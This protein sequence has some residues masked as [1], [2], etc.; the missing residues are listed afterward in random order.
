MR[1]PDG[2]SLSRDALLGGSPEPSSSERS[3]CAVCEK[4]SMSGC[5]KPDATATF[6]VRARCVFV[7]VD[8]IKIAFERHFGANSRFFRTWPRHAHDSRV[9]RR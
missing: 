4:K 5:K 3:Y 8:R 1:P 9:V 6:F 2:A 7:V